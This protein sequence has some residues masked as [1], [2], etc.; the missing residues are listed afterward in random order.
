MIEYKK[1]MEYSIKQMKKYNISENKFVSY[2]VFNTNMLLNAYINNHISGAGLYIY[3]IKLL[4]IVKKR[5]FI[6]YF[7][8]IYKKLKKKRKELK[9]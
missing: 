3:I 5:L 7:L 2:F 4:L 1:Q 9:K 8:N 6:Q